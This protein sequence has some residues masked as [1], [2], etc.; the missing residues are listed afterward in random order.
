M[1]YFCSEGFVRKLTDLCEGEETSAHSKQLAGFLINHAQRGLC[2]VYERSLITRDEMC[3][4]VV[5]FM[6]SDVFPLMQ[7]GCSLAVDLSLMSLSL[8]E[9]ARNLNFADGRSVLRH[10]LLCHETDEELKAITE[11]STRIFADAILWN[12]DEAWRS[13]RQTEVYQGPF[14]AMC[15]ILVPLDLPALVMERILRFFLGG[16]RMRLVPYHVTFGIANNVQQSWRRRKAASGAA[17]SADHSTE[18]PSQ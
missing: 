10:A 17:S 9:C 4:E 3:D 5:R 8:E 7:T 16:Y 13:E 6:Q 12:C 18:N 1:T 2:K 14:L 15:L 11:F